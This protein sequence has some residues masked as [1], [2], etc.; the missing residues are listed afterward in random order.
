M[1]QYVSW[2]IAFRVALVLVAA[3]F[4]YFAVTFFQVWRAARSDDARPSQAIVVLGAAQYDG[5]P[6]AVLQA[7]LAPSDRISW[8]RSGCAANSSRRAR[9][10]PKNQ[11]GRAHV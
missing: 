6:S 4:L 8:T 1:L 5:R 10:S 2:R 9:G 3:G 11:I 7:R